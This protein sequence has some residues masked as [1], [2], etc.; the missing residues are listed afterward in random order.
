MLVLPNRWIRNFL[1][2]LAAEN[3]PIITVEEAAVIGGFGSAVLEYYQ[4][5]EIEMP[6]VKILGVPDV[7]VEHGSINDQ[8]KEVGLTPE[9]IADTVNKL[10][11][12]KIQ[13]A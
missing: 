9:G 3:I 5:K 11:S 13:K 4:Q 10:I 2:Q 6:K 8:R 12:Q 1:D 7:Y